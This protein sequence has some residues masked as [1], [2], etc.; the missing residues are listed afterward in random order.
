MKTIEKRLANCLLVICLLSACSSTKKI[1]APESLYSTETGREKAYKSYN[2]AL[3]LFNFEF[4]ED[5]VA[6]DYGNTHLIVSGKDTGE[7]LILLPGLFA[8]ASMWY[9]NMGALSEYYRVY[10]LDMI[11]YGGKGK[12]YG[13]AINSI[14][15][16]VVWFNQLLNHYNLSKVS[17]AGLSYGSWL[18]LALARE[19]PDKISSVVL[20]DPSETFM[21]MN[22][23][24]AWKGFRYFMFFPNRKKYE[25]FF[26]WIGGGYTDPK[27]EIWF[28]HMLDVIEFGSVKMFDVPQHRIYSREEL[29]MINMPVLIMAGGKPILYDNPEEFK[30]NALQALPHAKVVIVPDAGHGLNMEKPRVVNCQIIRFLNRDKPLGLQPENALNRVDD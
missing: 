1:T 21:P 5:Y 6:T 25:K 10:A 23:G 7:V 12:P 14:N 27:M 24:I 16:Y 9:P 28:E 22:G 11:N 19:M 15:D 29:R 18:A 3:S 26:T 20:L 30:S 17:V 4:T 8:D 13:K 2:K